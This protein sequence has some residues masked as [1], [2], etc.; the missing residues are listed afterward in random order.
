V[1]Y[2][3]FALLKLV[4]IP[5]LNRPLSVVGVSQTLSCRVPTNERVFFMHGRKIDRP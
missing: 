1:P 2:T 4:P 3:Q 5:I